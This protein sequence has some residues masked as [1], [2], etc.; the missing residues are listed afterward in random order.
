MSKVTSKQKKIIISSPVNARHVG[1]INITG[2]ESSG[3]HRYFAS[4]MLEPDNLPSHTF[5]A[6]GKSEMP[7]ISKTLVEKLRKPSLALVRS[8]TKS[9][10]TSASH[11]LPTHRRSKS[12]QIPKIKVAG[13]DNN[14][15]TSRIHSPVMLPHPHG[16]R[17]QRRIVVRPRRVDPG[18]AIDLDNVA[19][20]DRP[21]GFKEIMKVQD[22][23]QRMKLYKKARDYWASADHGLVEWTGKHYGTSVNVPSTITRNNN[24]PL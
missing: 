13:T 16:V 20:E 8:L 24:V 7:Q 22:F 2:M 9:N 18:T 17:D 15:T 12:E 10:Y 1:G 11:S 23:E 3:I 4:T 19:V 14:T 5:A 6:I 21:M